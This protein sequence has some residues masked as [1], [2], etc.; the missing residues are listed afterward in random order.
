M[1]YFFEKC[2]AIL[3]PKWTQL[4]LPINQD[5]QSPEGCM[6]QLETV[7]PIL[8][9][10]VLGL[11]SA[12]EPAGVFDRFAVGVLFTGPKWPDLQSLNLAQYVEDANIAPSNPIDPRF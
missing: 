12:A 4:P 9:E 6:F 7:R 1:A 3:T 11:P 2:N 5:A 10:N 8:E